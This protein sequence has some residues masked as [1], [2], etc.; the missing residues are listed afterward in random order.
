MNNYHRVKELFH[1]ALEREP[2]ERNAFLDSAC[3]G[4]GSLRAE[5]ESMIACFEPAGSFIETPAFEF[6]AGLLANEEIE[7]AAGQSVGPYRIIREIGRGG[8][9]TVY[10]AA[11]SD[12]QYHKQVAIKL[13]KRGMDTDFIVQRFRNER[14][15]LAHLDH[16]NIARL[17]DGGAT[18]EG[19]PFFIMEFI[20]GKPIDE[21]CELKQLSIVDRLKLFLTVCSAVSYAHQNL[22]IHRD[23]KPGNILITADGSPRLLDFGIAKLLN[24]ELS[25]QTIDHT[26]TVLRLMTPDYASPEQVKGET[27]TTASD[28]YSLGVLLF[29]LLTGHRPY[30]LKTKSPDEIERVICRQEPTK[31]SESLADPGFHRSNSNGSRQLDLGDPKSLR[32]DLDN[33]VLMAMRKEPGRRYSSVEQFAEDIRRHLEGLPVIARK[34]TFAYRATKFVQRHRVGVAAAALFLITLIG[35]V[36]ATIRQARIATAQSK[37]ATAERDHARREAAKA[38]RINKFLQNMISYANP[39][40]YS[41]GRQQ[42]GDAKV[43]DAL[44]DSATRIDTELADQ[45]EVRAELHHTVGD[46]YRALGM[47]SRAEH[48]FRSALTLYKQLYG[49]R[50]PK[51]AEALFYLGAVLYPN[52]E[53]TAAE[54]SY[55]QAIQMM[56]EVDPENEFLPF[57]LEDLGGILAVKGEAGSESLLNEALALFRK[58]YGEEHLTVATVFARLGDLY[59]HS[60]LDRAQAAYQ[61]C[62]DRLK[63]LPVQT[64]VGGA[65][66][67]LGRILIRKKSYDQ[68]EAVLEESLEQ[69]RKYHG[70]NNPNVADVLRELAYLHLFHK[71]EYSKA[72]AEIKAAIEIDRRLSAQGDTVMARDL[73]TLSHVLFQQGRKPEAARCLNEGLAIYKAARARDHTPPEDSIPAALVLLRRYNEAEP[74][75]LELYEYLKNSYGEA[76]SATIDARRHLVELY[77]AW[78]KPEMADRYR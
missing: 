28:V 7:S 27:I 63:R 39:A 57:M 5:V 64:D 43:I 61:E 10:L 38:A 25:S 36:I 20:D 2:A 71:P 1:Q 68:A 6:A 17:L 32:G 11:R 31:P 12:D 72:A 29:E 41:P 26:A 75:L 30:R 65:Q 54:E 49:E 33:I 42:R 73:G 19:L 35:G 76:Y 21:Y 52:G 37:V 60:D 13:I 44:N 18:D 55:R 53:P 3:N 51:V 58:R 24:P 66:L 14:Q 15:I 67:P 34:D 47:F 46:A 62:I 50:H 45:P 4:D 40:W 74:L 69:A 56:R 8:M 59:A 16:P 78:G 48:H 9:G 22:V 77:E 70:D 23:L